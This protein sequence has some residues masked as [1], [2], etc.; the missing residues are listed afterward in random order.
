MY[1][2]IDS[3]STYRTTY[4]SKFFSFRVQKS[5]V[6]FRFTDGVLSE[7]WHAWKCLSFAFTFVWWFY[8]LEEL[9]IQNFSSNN[10]ENTTLVFPSIH[11]LLWKVWCLFDLCSFVDNM[12][13]SYTSLT[14][15]KRVFFCICLA[16]R[17]VNSLYVKI[18]IVNLLFFSSGEFSF[19]YFLDFL[20]LPLPQFS[21]L[22][23]LS[24]LS[25]MWT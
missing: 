13:H 23:T 24:K 1:P 20:T 14:P 9:S 8:S 22:G 25:L 18:Y 15:S 6:H 5:F 21:P 11:Y 19:S 16:W 10:I 2:F 7:L 17:S 12:F 4:S 3:F